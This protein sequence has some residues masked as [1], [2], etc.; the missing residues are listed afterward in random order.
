MLR[1]KLGLH[2]VRLTKCSK[3]LRYVTQ[4]RRGTVVIVHD[5]HGVAM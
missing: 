3:G 1:T 2:E 5:F 4:L